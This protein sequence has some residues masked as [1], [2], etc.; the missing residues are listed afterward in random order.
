MAPQQGLPRPIV[1]PLL[2]TMLLTQIP[3]FVYGTLRSD[4]P[5]AH[6]IAPDATDWQRAE[7]WGSL[8][9]VDYVDEKGA[10]ARTV[11]YSPKGPSRI[12]GDLLTLAPHRSLSTLARLDRKELNFGLVMQRGHEASCV[13]V[14]QLI[15][16]TPDGGPSVM[17]WTYVLASA[18]GGLGP[19][20]QPDADGIVRY[21]AATHDN[22][23]HRAQA[24]LE[25][26][27]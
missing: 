24:T 20:A 17:A 26:H 16:V 2:T 4:G 5:N 12:E 11:T 9:Y 15:L 21:S 19:A 7:A 6:L 13:F 27:A 10:R 1:K 8:H 14:R 3:I 25:G 18:H 22:T 23:R